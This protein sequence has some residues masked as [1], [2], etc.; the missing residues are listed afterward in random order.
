MKEVA[1]CGGPYGFRI[2]FWYSG[3]EPPTVETGA[4]KDL[5]AFAGFLVVDGV[6]GMRRD[7]PVQL[8]A[9]VQHYQIALPTDAADRRRAVRASL[10]L[11]RI[12]PE[13]I[14][15][16]LLAGVYRA[17]LG[18]VGFNLFLAGPSG[19]FFTAAIGDLGDRPGTGIGRN[20]NLVTASLG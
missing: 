3:E 7:V 12:A 6:H 20:E 4:R 11:L 19:A 14:T 9:A 5:I 2:L 16:P 13:R 1:V 18:T 15:L 17:A 8:N 10:Q